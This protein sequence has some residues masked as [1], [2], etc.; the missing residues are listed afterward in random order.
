MATPNFNREKLQIRVNYI[1]IFI[2]SEFKKKNP[3]NGIIACFIS[4]K[5]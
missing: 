4:T 1:L 5:Y 2:R 3:L